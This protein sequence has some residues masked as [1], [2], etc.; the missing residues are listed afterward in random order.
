MLDHP[1]FN[2]DQIK[3]PQYE[4]LVGEM[5][6]MVSPHTHTCCPHHL[7]D[8]GTFSVFSIYE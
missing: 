5:L 1:V 7:E 8:K 6:N 4:I 2:T 3:N